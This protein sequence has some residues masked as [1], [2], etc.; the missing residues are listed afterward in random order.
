MKT[1]AEVLRRESIMF[2]TSKN[3]YRKGEAKPYCKYLRRDHNG[4]HI[5]S[6]SHLDFKPSELFL[7]PYFSH[8]DVQ[9]IE[10]LFDGLFYKMGEI[11]PGK[12]IAGD[13]WFI[14]EP[15]RLALTVND[16]YERPEYF[17]PIYSEI[18]K[19]YRSF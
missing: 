16:V 5:I 2:L 19:D 18:A 13:R 14:I 7:H 10:C 6:P 1:V 15:K 11:Y 17:R 4:K 9:N 8:L 3:L 12:D